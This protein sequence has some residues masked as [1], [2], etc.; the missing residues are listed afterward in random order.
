MV[1]IESVKRVFISYSR[2]DQE[3][4]NRIAEDLRKHGIE[5]WI[6][7]EGLNPGTPDWELAI[8]AA[9]EESFAVLLIATPNSMK[10]PFVRS[11]VLLTQAKKL[12]IYAVWAA[13]EEWIDAIPMTLAHIQYLDLRS[14]YY[15]SNFSMLVKELS[16][17][18]YVLP[19]IFTYKSFYKKIAPNEIIPADYKKIGSIKDYV[20]DENN[21]VIC[22]ELK[23]II[24]NNQFDHLIEL[25]LDLD[26][27]NIYDEGINEKDIVLINPIRFQTCIQLLN[28]LYTLCLS[29][30]FPPLTYGLKWF[31][32][33]RSRTDI[34]LL[35]IENLLKSK[36]LNLDLK[37]KVGSFLK[38]PIHYGLKPGTRWYILKNSNEKINI[39]LAKQND[40]LSIMLQSP[41]V[42]AIFLEEY[43]E[44]IHKSKVNY[45]SI[46][47]SVALLID[48]GSYFQVDEGIYIQKKIIPADE[49]KYFDRR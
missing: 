13:G 5:V 40:L 23:I 7:F 9:V 45:R 44:K 24:K 22:R 38:S 32:V 18:L 12:P 15:D 20:R 27:K 48:Y 43:F 16:K 14:D 41:K 29:S 25:E 6:D 8:R 47:D 37:H 36:S 10:S 21:Y 19:S 46:K 30:R 26:N 2:I 39:L 11:E 1:V 17:N 33:K 35:D 49:K 31:M 28:E 3:F 42:M 34:V 4:A